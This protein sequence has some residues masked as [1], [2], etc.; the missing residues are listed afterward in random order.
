[1]L[2]FPSCLVTIW[3]GRP[4]CLPGPPSFHHQPA[5]GKITGTY[6][7]LSKNEIAGLP[8]S[9]KGVKLCLN[10]KNDELGREKKETK[11]GRKS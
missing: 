8:V 2:L 5:S 7:C 11:E 10:G 6:A 3:E 4:A 1:M 9:E